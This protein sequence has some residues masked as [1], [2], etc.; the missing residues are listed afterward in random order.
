MQVEL[1]SSELRNLPHVS[2]QEGWSN[3]CNGSMGQGSVTT[4]VAFLLPLHGS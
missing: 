1:V 3:V 4:F 2:Q